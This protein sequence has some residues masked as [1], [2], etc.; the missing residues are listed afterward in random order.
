VPLNNG[1]T[2]VPGWYTA[3]PGP[4]GGPPIMY[5]FVSPWTPGAIWEPAAVLP[6]TPGAVWNPTISQW[7]MP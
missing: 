1:I 7:T 3:T 5:H 6:G 4:P 2:G